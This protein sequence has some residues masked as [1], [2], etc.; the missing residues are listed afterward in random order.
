[1]AEM[2]ATSTAARSEKEREV[3]SV[4]GAQSAPTCVACPEPKL[5]VRMPHAAAL[6]TLVKLE[7][8]PRAQPPP[9][10]VTDTL[11]IV[12]DHAAPP[13]PPVKPQ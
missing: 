1:M 3:L 10:C 2:S 4:V 12:C 7:K 11:L 8:V 5:C 13:V 6:P 9:T